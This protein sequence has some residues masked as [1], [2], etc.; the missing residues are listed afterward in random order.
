MKKLLA[1]F[2]REDEGQ[3][4]IEYALLAG[5]IALAAVLMIYNVGLGLNTIY[6]KVNAQVSSAAQ[7]S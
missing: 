5:F 3:D 4:L 2:V 7:G 6:S 1:R